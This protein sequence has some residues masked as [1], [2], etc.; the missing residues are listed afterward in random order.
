M[1]ATTCTPT[2]RLDQF[3]QQTGWPEPDTIQMALRMEE[4]LRFFETYLKGWINLPLAEFDRGYARFGDNPYAF[5]WNDKVT[6]LTSA[7]QGINFNCPVMVIPLK[8]GDRLRRYSRSNEKYGEA[9]RGLWYTKPH[10]PASILA[11]PPGQNTAYSCE[12]T[13]QTNVLESTA[14]DMLVDWGMDDTMKRQ[15]KRGR[16]YHYRRGGGLQYTIPNAHDVL[17]QLYDR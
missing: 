17:R 12:V 2:P 5:R 16:D 7:M 4:A 3:L 10:V 1:Y 13:C 15:P 11:L 9:V 6:K 8:V 14:G